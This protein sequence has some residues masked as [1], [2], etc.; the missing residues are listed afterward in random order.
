MFRQKLGQVELG[1]GG[2]QEEWE[3]LEGRVKVAVE[4]SERER[5]GRGEERNG[6]WDKE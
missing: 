6:W 5:D 1:E 4:G 3:R 2:V